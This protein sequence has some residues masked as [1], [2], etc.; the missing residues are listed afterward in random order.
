MKNKKTM[1]LIL[2]T[3]IVILII[4]IGVC[5]YLII[6]DII[7]KEQR[8]N[9]TNFTPEKEECSVV[10]EDLNQIH[11]LD[12]C[13]TS[14]FTVNKVTLDGVDMKLEATFIKGK[15]DIFTINLKL[16]D[17]GISA[18]NFSNS[19]LNFYRSQV[20]IIND[21]LLLIQSDTGDQMDTQ[22]ITIIN[23]QKEVLLNERQVKITEKEENEFIIHRYNFLSMV[24]EDEE[25]KDK[26][27]EVDFTY[28]LED[29]KIKLKELKNITCNEYVTNGE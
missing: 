15:D 20:S 13:T 27:F 18:A 17:K 10:T 3:L 1:K 12:G 7:K 5:A 6:T 8:K 29:N 19:A 25:N 16:D 22:N 4:S 14:T 26:I 28:T 9:T 24:C 2:Y 23:N 21:S 11:P